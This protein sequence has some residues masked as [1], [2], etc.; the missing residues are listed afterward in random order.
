MAF[1]RPTLS[2]LVDRIQAD[3]ISR[4]GG[5][6]A[7]LRRSIV[8]V[9]ARVMAGAVHMLY[10]A[11]DYLSRQLFADVAD[12][13][14]LVRFASLYGLSKTAATFATGPITVTGTNG[15]D[16]NTGA[17]L[18]RPDGAEYTVDAGGTISG[19]TLAL[20][21]TAVLAGVDGNADAG[22]VLTFESPLPGVDAAATVAVGGLVNGADIEGTESLR[23]RLLERIR[24]APQGGA[25]SDYTGWALEVAGVTR[26]WVYPSQMGAGTVVVYFVRDDDVGSSIPSAG[27][28][29]AVQTYIDTVRP[30]T[31]AVTVAAPTAKTWNFTLSVVPNTTDVKAAV[32]A[33]LT[34]LFRTEGE[35]GTTLPLS[36]VR[37]A[38][39]I[40]TGIT[41]YTLTTP[42]ADLTHA[43]GEIPVLGTITWS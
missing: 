36:R 43:A 9:L 28:V 10:G 17:V 7:A 22:T 13:A 27:E 30:V 24:T 39:G 20:T 35:P 19:G 18:R 21:V 23:T 3:L 14:Y 25:A 6:G 41:D 12:D 15:Q 33:E 34:D 11:L 42:N 8:A 5:S 4:L 2:A 38:I 1:D 37:T 29:T 32:T 26:V 40:A 31:A 16:V